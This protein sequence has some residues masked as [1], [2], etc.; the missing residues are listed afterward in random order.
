LKKEEGEGGTSPPFPMRKGPGAYHHPAG[1]GEGDWGR[2]I[3]G[4]RTSLKLGKDPTIFN[5]GNLI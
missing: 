1:G 2:V 4:K 3:G 5:Q